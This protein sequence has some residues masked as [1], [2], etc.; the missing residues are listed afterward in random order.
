MP[1]Q[2]CLTHLPR[3][4]REKSAGVCLATNRATV[5]RQSV[6]SNRTSCA[7]LTIPWQSKTKGVSGSCHEK[8]KHEHKQV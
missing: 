6:F 4:A 5:G 1:N 8:T 2:Q 3:N 7:E